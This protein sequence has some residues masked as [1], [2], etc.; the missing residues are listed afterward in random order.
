MESNLAKPDAESRTG[1]VRDWGRGEVKRY[2]SKG[3]KFQLP[4]MNKS[5]RSQFLNTILG[6]SKSVKRVALMLNVLISPR[7]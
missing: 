6:T 3:T 4:K 1:L 5:W 7:K 2:S